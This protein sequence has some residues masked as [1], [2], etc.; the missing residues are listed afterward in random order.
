MPR[1]IAAMRS[2]CAISS[3]RCWPRVRTIPA[4]MPPTI[5]T[6]GIE[7]N[8]NGTKKSAS[9]RRICMR[10]LL[11]SSR[12]TR[13]PDATGPVADRGARLTRHDRLD[14]SVPPPG[15]RNFATRGEGWRSI[16]CRARGHRRSGGTYRAAPGERPAGAPPAPHPGWSFLKPDEAAPRSKKL[17]EPEPPDAVLVLRA[18]A[19]DTVAF[20]T[21][22]ER[23]RDRAYTLAL[24]MLRAPAD[25]E[26]V[27]QD[28]FVRAWVGLPRFRGESSF[29]TWLHRIVARRALDRAAG[30]RRR[31]ERETV[32]E[33]AE[34][35]PDGAGCAAG[36][37]HAFRLEALIAELTAAQREVVALFYYEGRSVEQVASLLAIPAGTVKTHLSRARSALRRG[38]LEAERIRRGAE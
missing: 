18:Q 5:A 37:E 16:V 14:R 21:L 3:R 36:A 24:R 6:I 28:A 9:N 22:I 19:G 17:G 29:G 10:V 30:L 32:V 2:R 7:N 11:R 15:F 31:R 26:E 34:Q 1:S 33:E 4:V 27:A 35:L 23:H 13:M 8:R 25:A 20:R 12:G 38:W